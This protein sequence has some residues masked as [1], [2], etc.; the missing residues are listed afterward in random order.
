MAN[1]DVMSNHSISKMNMAAFEKET[2]VW[3]N[4]HGNSSVYSFQK[5]LLTFFYEETILLFWLEVAFTTHL[6]SNM[7]FFKKIFRWIDWS[8][9]PKGCRLWIIMCPWEFLCVRDAAR[10]GNKITDTGDSRLH[11]ADGGQND[12]V[13]NVGCRPRVL[14]CRLQTIDFLCE[15]YDHFSH[16]RKQANWSIIKANLSVVS[17]LTGVIFSLTGALFHPTKVQTPYS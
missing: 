12:C 2:V 16:D 13:W 17:R 4:L 5:L 10:R 3:A 1:I 14:K 7:V 15:W 8:L 11:T 9:L 6:K